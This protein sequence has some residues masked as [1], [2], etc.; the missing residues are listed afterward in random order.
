MPCSPCPG[1]MT[2]VPN[3]RA[4]GRAGIGLC[5]AALCACTLNPQPLPPGDFAEAGASAPAVGGEDASA[6]PG[7]GAAADGAFAGQD[8]SLGPEA[9][10]AGAN[11]S[12]RGDGG[13]RDGGLGDGSVGEVDGPTGAETDAVGDGPADAGVDGEEHGE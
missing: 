13:P 8:G 7:D 10:E 11:D 12:G 3:S 5:L 1:V 4:L 6:G 9:A 2:L